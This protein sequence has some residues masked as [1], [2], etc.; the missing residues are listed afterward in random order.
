MVST[1][2]TI[3]IHNEK[4]RRD[5]TS[6]YHMS[7]PSPELRPCG[8]CTQLERPPGTGSAAAQE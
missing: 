4:G 7:A 1:V 2:W 3:D 6:S 5:Q 8:L